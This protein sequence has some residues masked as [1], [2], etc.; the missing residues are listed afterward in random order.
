LLISNRRKTIHLIQVIITIGYT[1]P[2]LKYKG[3]TIS[4]Q[5]IRGKKGP[6]IEEVKSIVNEEEQKKIM[7]QSYKEVKAETAKYLTD[8]E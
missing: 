6:K 7:E 4:A 1:I 3:K 5:R 2:K 8:I